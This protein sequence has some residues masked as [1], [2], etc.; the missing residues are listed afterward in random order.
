MKNFRKGKLKNRQ[1]FEGKKFNLT[2]L[3]TNF[4]YVRHS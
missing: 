3:Y 2:S 1:S 4:E